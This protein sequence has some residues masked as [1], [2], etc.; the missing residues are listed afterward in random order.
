MTRASKSAPP[1]VDTSLAPVGGKAHPSTPG[2]TQAP[3]WV[4]TPSAK[5]GAPK[6]APPS[7]AP[8]VA[9]PKEILLSM[10]VPPSP[11]SNGRFEGGLLETYERNLIPG[12][13][14]QLGPGGL[15][16]KGSAGHDTGECKRCCFFPKGRCTNG[17]ECEFCHF[18]H[19]KRMR[20]KR[21]KPLD[22]T[23]EI[24]LGSICPTPTGGVGSPMRPATPA[25]AGPAPD[26]SGFAELRHPEPPNAPPSG[27]PQEAPRQN[28]AAPSLH[29]AVPPP[30]WMAGGE[31]PPGYWASSMHASMTPHGT[32]A[33]SWSPNVAMPGMASPSTGLW[34]Q[35]DPGW[36]MPGTP[37]AWGQG[38][39]Q[40]GAGQIQSPQVH[41]S[42]MLAYGAMPSQSPSAPPQSPSLSREALL[43][44]RSAVKEAPA[45]AAKITVVETPKGTKKFMPL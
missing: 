45:P 20:K 15:P 43:R 22:G 41:L 11:V 14:V 35:G 39:P 32:P 40:W 5:G 29:A 1:T 27:V 9:A 8:T 10:A 26:I 33:Y 37:G 12:L 3:A 24:A 28:N 42:S 19:E 4:P 30:A 25:P 23:G 38:V 2:G 21:P 7:D 31:H 18:D 6:I 34:P 17:Y 44:Y 36:Y 13:P 16:S